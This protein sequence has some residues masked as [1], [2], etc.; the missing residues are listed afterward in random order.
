MRQ[1][2]QDHGHREPEVPETSV[3]NSEKKK[4]KKPSGSGGRLDFCSKHFAE[5]N[6]QNAH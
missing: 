2:K 1:E 6:Y 3:I 5:R 4:K